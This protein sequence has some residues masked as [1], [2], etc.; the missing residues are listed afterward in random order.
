MT[1][2]TV[3]SLVRYL[4]SVEQQWRGEDHRAHK[5]VQ[6]VKGHEINGYV[7]LGPVGKRRK[8]DNSNG[9]EGVRLA[10]GVLAKALKAKLPGGGT[11]VP[12]PNSEATREVT[13]FR[14]LELAKIV[15]SS[16][17]HGYAVRPNLRWRTAKDP[18]HK[19][20]GYRDP[21]ALVENLLL[22][23]V[24]PA[25]VILFDD[26]ITS[27]SQMQASFRVLSE[28]GRTPVFGITVGRTTREQHENMLRWHEEELEIDS[29]DDW[30]F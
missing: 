13:T 5:L 20:S 3:G 14:T 11:I 10:L 12:I 26:V 28:A 23:E 8:F 6:L 27:G 9:E 24:P 21:D 18:A 25:P 1:S 29:A 4:T 2:L 30:P 17:G 15:A 7:Y 22:T 19:S 16:A